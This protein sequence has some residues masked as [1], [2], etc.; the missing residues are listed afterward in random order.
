MKIIACAILCVG[1]CFVEAYKISIG[2]EP[3]R[4][5]GF[6]AFIAALIVVL[7]PNK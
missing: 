3:S 4:I 2:K 7:S 5:E 1:L 6:F